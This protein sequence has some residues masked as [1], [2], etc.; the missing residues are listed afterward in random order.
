M[1][2]LLVLAVIASA[3]SSIGA[4]GEDPLP[5][6]IGRV[7]LGLS[8]CAQGG[9]G[10]CGIS[11]PVGGTGVGFESGL[12]FEIGFEARVFRWVAL[13]LGAGRYRPAIAV[14]R[15]LGQDVRVD[16]R[17]AVA[18]LRTITFET[19]VTP[20]KWRSDVGRVAI[21]VLLAYPSISEAPSSLGLSLDAGSPGFGVDFRGD[22]FL[23][24]NRRWGIGG[25]LAFVSMDPEFEDL[26][27][28]DRGSVQTGL[29]NLRLGF[30]GNW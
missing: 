23:S 25:A 29:L 3:A 24:K 15:D 1:R 8:A 17:D 14:Y 5:R 13:G 18:D 11:I 12:G 6:W 22:W 4:S 28:G 19:V 27:T 9:K 20:P 21:G 10:G 30:R 7:D 26:E 16:S 2:I